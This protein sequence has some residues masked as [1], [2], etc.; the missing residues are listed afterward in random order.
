MQLPKNHYQVISQLK[1]YLQK[2]QKHVQICVFKQHTRPSESNANI[3]KDNIRAG[4]IS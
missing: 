1:T 4:Q 2:N 3:V